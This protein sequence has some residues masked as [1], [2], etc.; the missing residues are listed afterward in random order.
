[1]MGPRQEALPALYYEFSLEDL[2]GKRLSLNWD[3]RHGNRLNGSLVAGD[4]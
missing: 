1:M 4:G 2:R 3:C